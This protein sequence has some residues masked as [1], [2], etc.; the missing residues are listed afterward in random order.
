[1]TSEVFFDVA[2]VVAARKTICFPWLS[3]HIA[4]VEFQRPARPDGFS[5]IRHQQVGEQTGIQATW[6]NHDQISAEDGLQRG[7]IG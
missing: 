5:D 6:S 4:H 1:M 3:S 2:D 7:R